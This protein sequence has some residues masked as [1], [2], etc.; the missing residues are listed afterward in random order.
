MRGFFRFLLSIVIVGMILINAAHALLG[1]IDQN[2]AN[3]Q[4]EGSKSSSGSDNTI[5]M[6][7]SVEKGEA[8]IAR[9]KV[10]VKVIYL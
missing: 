6:S 4:L 10:I 1:G 5:N 2:H 3:Q 8:T 7:P 9:A